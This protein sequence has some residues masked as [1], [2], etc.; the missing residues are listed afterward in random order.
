MEPPSS[1]SSIITAPPDCSETARKLAKLT[2][3]AKT[4]RLALLHYD[5]ASE[6]MVEW[7]W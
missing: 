3:E 1:P 7:C 4:C 5:S 2:V 6:S